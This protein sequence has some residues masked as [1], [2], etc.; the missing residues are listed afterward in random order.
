M[1]EPPLTP[2][3][4]QLPPPSA[5]PSAQP[6]IAA[7]PVDDPGAFH[8]LLAA[9]QAQQRRQEWLTGAF[10]GGAA[11]ALSLAAAG[12][13]AHASAGL[14]RP[15]IGDSLYGGEPADRLMLHAATLSF[16]E[17]GTK[18]RVSFESAAPF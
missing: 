10:Y 11:L 2:P 18:R 4:P 3:G 8:R 12:F 9:V 13:L 14:G 16:L 1:I 5:P 6:V 17:P 15:I 7:E